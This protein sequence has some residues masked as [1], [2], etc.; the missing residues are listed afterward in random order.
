MLKRQRKQLGLFK[1]KNITQQTSKPT[2]NTEVVL[3]YGNW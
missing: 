3:I 2:Q 1:K